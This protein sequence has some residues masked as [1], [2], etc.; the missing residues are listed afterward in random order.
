[1]TNKGLI[2]KLYQLTQLKYQKAD[3]PIKK[4][5][6]NLN[7]LFRIWFSGCQQAHKKILNITNQGNANAKEISPYTCQNGYQKINKRWQ[8]CGEKREPMYSVG[9]YV[10][11]FS[12]Y[13]KQYGG[14][15]KLKELSHDTPTDS[16]MHIWKKYEI[17][18]S[19]WYMHPIFIAALFTIASMWKQPRCA[20][21]VWIKIS[22]YIQNFLFNSF[23]KK[24]KEWNSAICRNMDKPRG[25]YT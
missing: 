25:H 1:M 10:N 5:A 13:G 17:T 16:W 20:S 15:P 24:K 6:A 12:H 9:G 7:R 4:W 8:E 3:H 21:D 19:K 22:L 11:W 18:N 2:S 14:S 23:K